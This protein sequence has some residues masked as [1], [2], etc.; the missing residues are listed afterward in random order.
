MVHC[1]SCCIYGTWRSKEEGGREKDFKVIIWRKPQRGNQL[2]PSRHHT[3][4]FIK[5]NVKRY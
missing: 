3:N 5:S 4:C 2:A 1:H